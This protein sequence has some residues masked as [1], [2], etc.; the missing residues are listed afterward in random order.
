MLL[1]LSIEKKIHT[2]AGENLIRAKLSLEA[3]T[4]TALKGS[5]GCGKTTL[6]RMISGLTKPDSGSI[7]GRGQLWFDNI[8]GINIPPR[9]RQTGFLFQEAPL[10]PNMTLKENLQFAG[11][12]PEETE[13]MLNKVQLSSLGNRYPSRLSGG[14]R[15]RAALALALTVKNDILLLDEPF[16][17]VDNKIRETLWSILLAYREHHKAAVL[18]VTH[19]QDNISALAGRCINMNSGTAVDEDTTAGQS[20]LPGFMLIDANNREIK[21]YPVFQKRGEP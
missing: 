14:Q 5:S 4:I 11:G 17:A 20:I 13:D 16:S 18:L 2:A 3:N 6:L 19:D 12:S 9:E 15:Q 1:S 8:S 10:F 7:T 21:H